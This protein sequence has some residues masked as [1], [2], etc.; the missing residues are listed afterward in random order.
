MSISTAKTT[1]GTFLLLTCLLTTAC[2]SQPARRTSRNTTPT[3]IDS[4]LEKTKADDADRLLSLLDSIEEK[5]LV[6]DARIS[7]ERAEYYYDNEQLRA[8]EYY[9]KKALATDQLQ[10]EEATWFYNAYSNLSTV[11]YNKGDVEGSIAAATKG[12]AIARNDETS[13]GRHFAARLLSHIGS[14]QLRLDRYQEAC[15]SYLRAYSSMKQQA[16]A[17]SSYANVNAW[18]TMAN[19]ILTDYSESNASAEAAQWIDYAGTAVARLTSLADCPP[20]R[21][22]RMKGR[23]MA[24]KAI[25]MAKQGRQA[26]AEAAYKALLAT[27]FSKTDDGLIDKITSLQACKRWDEMLALQPR[28]DSLDKAWGTP[29]NLDYVTGTLALFFHADVNSGRTKEALAMAEQIVSS[30]DSI[31][32]IQQRNAAAELA[33]IYETQEKEAKIAE[34]NASLVRQQLVATAIALLLF[35]IFFTIFFYFR[36][37]AGKRLEKAH[38]ELLTAYDQLEETTTAKERIESE[39]RIARDIQMSMVPQEFP[40][41]PD[42]DLYALM[43]PAREVGGDLYDY[44]LH[45]DR[46]YFCVGDVSGKGVPASL[47]MAQVIR[48]FRAL[49]KQGQS[50]AQIANRLNDELSENN[51]SSMF[52]TMF[53]GL[54]NLH[55]GHLSFCNAGHNPPVIGGLPPTPSEGRG[56]ADFLE[57]AS[58]APIGLWPDLEFVGEEIS[59]IKGRPLFVYTDGL[60]EAEN[61]SQQQ[62]GDERLLSVLRDTRFENAEQVIG[63]MQSAVEQHR[64]GADPNDD[65][66]M[67]CLRIIE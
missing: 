58:N 60:N 16:E 50:P 55:T 35:V 31:N 53:I 24:S 33:V 67:L 41:R 46:L 44:I 11:L 36:H 21:A 18:A 32:V 19:N 8:S 42:L 66:T 3:A 2:S 9:F 27:D 4:L 56:H 22:D 65:L 45:A 23:M 12:Y 5:G 38:E 20:E 63:Q 10:K 17:D 62:F 59:S 7:Y 47:F 14:C 34:Q 54:I 28:L 49:A 43:T 37:R 6:S 1:F 39:L 26:D 40:T 61:C 29:L 30:L 64:D 48:L 15:D 25:I 52:V 51:D 13:V 57:M